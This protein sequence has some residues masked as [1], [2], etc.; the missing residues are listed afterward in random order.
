[1]TSI[2]ES[3]QNLDPITMASELYLASEHTNEFH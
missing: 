1:M 3:S 2:G